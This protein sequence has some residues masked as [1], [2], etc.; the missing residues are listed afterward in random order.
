MNLLPITLS[1]VLLTSTFVSLC[2]YA[3]LPS[4][5]NALRVLSPRA[6]A[7]WSLFFLAAPFASSLL[8]VAISFAHC[9][10]PTALGEPDDC[11]NAVGIVCAFCFSN[12]AKHSLVALFLAT[13]FI[14]FV[15]PRLASLAHGIFLSRR[16]LA[17]L[18]MV[19]RPQP[20]G[21]WS[22]PGTGAFT[23]GWP[24]PVACI[25]EDL[26]K[27]LSP[28]ALDAITAH[29]LAHVTR[30][31]VFARTLARVVSVFHLPSV[32]RSLLTS[33][34]LAHERACDARASSVVSSPLLVAQT[35]LDTH[36]LTHSANL[37]E[38]VSDS[39]STRVIALCNTS[40]NSSPRALTVTAVAITAVT[41][42]AVFSPHQV[43]RL[44]E[45]IAGLL[46]A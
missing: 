17:R 11:T 5:T 45:L 41:T 26:G 44:A 8:I 39:L 16:A 15:S 24:A 12:P 40:P 28:H 3:V 9:A 19:A 4:V 18:R 34:E 13:L 43:H 30:N 21:T 36:R 33:L 14:T 20:N 1:I 37:S 7:R 10:V 35:L 25:G 27:V 23:I 32:S 29:E 2:L 6:S 42:L 31:D 22:I 38:P 46:S